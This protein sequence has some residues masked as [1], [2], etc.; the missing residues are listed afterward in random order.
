DRRTPPGVGPR[1]AVGSRRPLADRT[2]VQ[3]V[4]GAELY[5][6]LTPVMLRQSCVE[7]L[8]NHR[9]P[10]GVKPRPLPGAT[11]RFAEVVEQRH[12]Q[13]P[14]GGEIVPEQAAVRT[15]GPDCHLTPSPATRRSPACRCGCTASCRRT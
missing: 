7:S 2:D 5:P 11:E 3:F 4:V 8:E 12:Q 6:R 13:S 15:T 10:D 14:A 1:V 9:R